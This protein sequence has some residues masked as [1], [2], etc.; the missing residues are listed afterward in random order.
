MS[1]A[2]DFMDKDGM[3]LFLEDWRPDR[4][5]LLGAAI[6]LFGVLVIMWGRDWF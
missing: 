6:A 4:F 2:P 5:D 3:M 1:V